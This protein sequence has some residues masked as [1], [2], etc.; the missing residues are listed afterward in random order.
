MN[1]LLY[2]DSNQ[3]CIGLQIVA[4]AIA[5]SIAILVQVTPKIFRDDQ[6]GVQYV[7]QRND[8]W[9]ARMR[10]TEH[11]KFNRRTMFVVS[12]FVHHSHGAVLETYNR[13]Y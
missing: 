1:G 11:I 12:S 13:L 8:P 4:D 7:A 9:R 3:S 2:S 10:I 6:P 5:K